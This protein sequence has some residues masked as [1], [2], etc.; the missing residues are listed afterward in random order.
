MNEVETPRKR[1]NRIRKTFPGEA[2]REGVLAALP[3]L[4]DQLKDPDPR[5]RIEAAARLRIAGYSLNKGPERQSLVEQFVALLQ[6]E[7]DVHVVEEV[8]LYGGWVPDPTI[9]PFLLEAYACDDN[10]ALRSL[11]LQIAMDSPYMLRYLVRI[12]GLDAQE[13][14]EAAF[15]RADKKD[16]TWIAGL[17]LRSQLEPNKPEW[18]E[19]ERRNCVPYDDVLERRLSFVR[20]EVARLLDDRNRPYFRHAEG[21]WAVSKPLTEWSRHLDANSRVEHWRRVLDM[22]GE[23]PSPS[24][25]ACRAN[26]PA[27]MLVQALASRASQST[28]VDNQVALQDINEAIQLANMIHNFQYDSVVDRLKEIQSRIQRL[29]AGTSECAQALERYAGSTYS[30]ST[31]LSGDRLSLTIDGR[32]SVKSWSDALDPC[33]PDGWTRE[34][35]Y[36]CEGNTLVLNPGPNMSGHGI[37]GDDV[38]TMV[39]WGHR[40]Y[41]LADSQM[42]D[43]CQGVNS[44]AM[45]GFWRGIRFYVST[46]ADDTP[47]GLPKVPAEWE[48][49]LLKRPV[50]AKI[51]EVKT[52]KN[53]LIDKGTES[54]LKPGMLVY[55]F[56]PGANVVWGTWNIEWVKH[57]RAL[58]SPLYDYAAPA[59]VGVR[60]STKR[61]DERATSLAPN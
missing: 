47:M 27:T 34:G 50:I 33:H 35:H 15:E 31:G 55:A 25:R 12:G 46:P 49:Y 56:D 17:V 8:F 48:E 7:S 61:A 5:V 54:G 3:T 43:F 13:L 29:R 16:R 51:K 53:V 10:E 24:D 45:P 52:N 30:R 2:G 21:Q 42:M 4:F 39:P 19:A 28:G 18:T 41:L 60:V 37:D 6:R 36:D 59:T 20:K 11:A 32:Y 22:L 9:A 38:L 57:R 26:G 1:G 23:A 40:L 58:A 44:G 14:L